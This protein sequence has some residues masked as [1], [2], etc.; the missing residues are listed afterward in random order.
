MKDYMARMGA[1]YVWGELQNTT[2]TLV[3]SDGD[4]Y[5][6]NLEQDI[7]TEGQD[8]ERFI[9]ILD[10]MLKHVSNWKGEEPVDIATREEFKKDLTQFTRL[11]NLGT[12]KDRDTICGVICDALSKFYK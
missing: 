2:I 4:Q 11:F 10:V 9:T 7:P 5:D 1:L 3:D 12:E 6:Y 8:C